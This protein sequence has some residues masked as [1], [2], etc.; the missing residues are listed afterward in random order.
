MKL[1]HLLYSGQGGLG[2]Y[3][4]NFADS[5][6]PRQFEHHVIF[7]GI[8]P[9]FNEYEVYCRQRAI[10]FIYVNR[11]SKVDLHA[12]RQVN[13]YRKMNTI[14]AVLIH[15]VSLSPFYFFSFRR[16]FRV[17]AF[18]HTSGAFKTRIEWAFAALNHLLADFAIYFYE[19]QF[20]IIKKKW[21]F[22]RRGKNTLIIPKEVDTSFFKP[23]VPPASNRQFTLG[24]SSRLV[25][26]KRHD[27][28]VEAIRKLKE[29]DIH[30]HL[31]IAGEGPLHQPL[32]KQVQN[33]QL[34]D[35]VFFEGSLTRERMVHFYQSLDAYIHATNS[36]TICY[37]IK[38]AQATGLPIIASDVEGVKN[39]IDHRVSGLL[40]KNT[41]DDIVSSIMEVMNNES[42]RLKLA[43]QS[44]LLSTTKRK[45]NAAQLYKA[46]VKK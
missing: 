46:L 33:D 6:Q 20:G 41:A 29:K 23:A 8:E 5:D 11:G 24:I 44:L 27:L 39:E 36:E 40:F 25:A 21:P 35:Q 28:L 45:G 42:L 15:T 10:P 30:V 16:S 14:D 12:Y 34:E 7:Y 9:L 43:R 13:H 2:T 37:S 31:R 17:I 1:L 19:G 4:M 3:F 26:G 22:L 38:E 18:D 32:T